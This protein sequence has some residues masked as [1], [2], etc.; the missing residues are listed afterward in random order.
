MTKKI[1]GFIGLAMSLM[2]LIGCST[3]LVVDSGDTVKVNY[4]G[5]LED[6][7]VFDSSEGKTPLEFEVGSGSLI[8]G[9]ENAVYGLKVGDKKTITIP[10]DQ[11]YGP[12]H[13]EMV[14]KV[15]RAQFPEDMVLE[16]G[17]TLQLPQ[18]DGR[19]MNAVISE[20]DDSTVTLDGNHPLAGE[21]L[22]FDIEIVEI[23]KKS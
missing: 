8:P 10:V 20:I 6:G 13:E 14:G 15:P 11:A 19:A 21:T 16:V 4:T 12:R 1:I 5:K 3:E 2:L 22:I 23:V 7:S 18:P 9:F 17:R